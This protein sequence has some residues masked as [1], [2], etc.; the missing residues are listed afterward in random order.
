MRGMAFKA[1]TGIFALVLL[2]LCIGGCAKQDSKATETQQ[3]ET[4]A[5]DT[6]TQAAETQA[7]DV[8]TQTADVKETQTQEAKTQATDIKTTQTET[9][10]EGFEVTMEKQGIGLK[11]VENSRTLGG[12]PTAD[13]RKVKDGVLLRTGEL[14][15]ATTEDIEKL[16]G[17]HLATVVDF[18]EQDVIDIAPDPEIEAVKNVHIPVMDESLKE[19]AKGITAANDDAYVQ[20]LVGVASREGFSLENTYVEM[21]DTETGKAG[22]AEFFRILLNKKEG[23]AILFHCSYGKDRTGIA[24]A[25]FL[26]AMGVDEKIIQEDFE[27]TNKFMAQKIDGTIKVA[28]GFTKDEDVLT[29]VGYLVG[30]DP[31]AMK[32]LMEHLKEKYGSVYAFI[33]DGL[34]IS[35]EDLER[36]REMYLE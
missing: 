2:M 4:Q 12:Y 6:Q 34:M 33:T 22:F 18:R 28:E 7:K 1:Y 23:E 10:Q 15:N 14:F 30:V 5:A 11:G 31:N 9:L 26:T 8:Q 29:K 20:T 27:L 21:I 19:K 13:G 16:L 35:E 32:H 3:V 25:L 24:A 36:L 17:Y